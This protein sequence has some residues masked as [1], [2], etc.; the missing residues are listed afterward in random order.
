MRKILL[1]LLSIVAAISMTS[2]A[3]LFASLESGKSEDS[4]S[5]SVEDN[6]SSEKSDE[7]P[8]DI[9]THEG[10]KTEE[11][12]ATCTEAG[13][14]A[15]WTCE[16]G[17]IFSD[18]AC[19]A[20]ITLADTVIPAKGHSGVK[21]EAVEATCTEA[22]NIAYWTC[23]C[24][25]IFSDEACETEITLD[26][27][28]VTATGHE[29]DENG[30]CVCGRNLT[31]KNIWLSASENCASVTYTEG[32]GWKA[33]AAGTAN[34]YI[35]I[36]HETT[37]FFVEQGN[38][39]M[40]LTFCGAFDGATF[41]DS[42]PLNCRIWILPPNAADGSNDWN[43]A[44]SSKMQTELTKNAD[45]TYS[46]TIDLTNTAYDFTKYDLTIYVDYKAANTGG[47]V[48]ALYMSNIAYDKPVDLE[49][50][51]IWIN[52]SDG[53]GT[54][55]YTENSGWKISA[56]GNASYY[57][58]INHEVTASYIAKGNTQM[59][60]T[61]CGAF[62]GAT[63]G[64]SSPLNCR[65]WILPPKAAD[66]GNDWNYPIS[67]K[68]QTELDKN[69]DGTYSHTIDLT[70]TAYNFTK[71]DL[72]IYVDY[73]AANTGGVVGAIYIKD[74][75]YS[76]KAEDTEPEKAIYWYGADG[77][78][79]V[80]YTEGKGW[81]VSSLS[82]AADT[83]GVH[84]NFYLQ[85]EVIQ[86][87]VEEMG[88]TKLTITVGGSFDG[89]AHGGNPVNCQEW[90]I[91]KNSA[92]SDDW[93]Y[94]NGFFSGWTNTGNGTYAYTIDLTNVNYNFLDSDLRI[95]VSHNDKGTAGLSDASVG[96]TYIY[97]VV[98]SA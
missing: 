81:K 62:D 92:G 4:M 24:G 33:T 59:T 37:K 25:K 41:G 90:I 7:E 26:D 67:Q 82:T 56:A 20:E 61:F 79:S 76:V 10:V 12:E 50:R 13:N 60:L 63:F 30:A 42:N 16:C 43:Y 29:Y 55:A 85:K 78:C 94:K 22:G 2:C 77:E 21:T 86:Y 40:T 54:I 97:D 48:G 23:E 39:Q 36:S 31:D 70:N 96:A 28:V 98:F 51:S 65:I 52:G 83:S 71:Y 95:R 80:S 9:H 47:A 87:Y 45:G 66:G 89:T 73:K 74:I 75:A 53:C 35:K 44:V 3:D 84:Y 27:T 69:A 11:N 19:E 5:T 32:K 18:E 58:K 8:E 46:H 57:I 91:P 15:Y 6:G 68:M 14:I 88:A 1:A 72:T 49:D 64:N 17:K 93:N 34:Y 38:T